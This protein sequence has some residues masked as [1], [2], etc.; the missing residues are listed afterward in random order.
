MI[1]APTTT[2]KIRAIP[3]MTIRAIPRIW[4]QKLRAESISTALSIGPLMD[5]S[6]IMSPH[7]IS[8]EA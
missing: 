6:R 5:T 8:I 3:D 7:G 2:M 4:S 1:L